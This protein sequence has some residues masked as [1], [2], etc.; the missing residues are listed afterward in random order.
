MARTDG[1]VNCLQCDEPA[2]L[3]GAWRRNANLTMTCPNC[4]LVHLALN[5]VRLQVHHGLK[6]RGISNHE[7]PPTP[8]PIEP[9]QLFPNPDG[10]T[11]S[12]IRRNKM[13]GEKFYTRK[14]KPR[15]RPTT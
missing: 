5:A 10:K 13:G 14:V 9:V 1:W 3:P 8:L 2:E 4:G 11:E 7:K 12:V 6:A 15:P